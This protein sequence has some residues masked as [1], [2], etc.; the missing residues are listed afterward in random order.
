MRRSFLAFFIIER[1]DSWDLVLTERDDIFFPSSSQDAE[2]FMNSAQK[3]RVKTIS[4]WLSESDA[5]QALWHIH[6]GDP[7]KAHQPG[8]PGTLV[9]DRTI[10]VAFDSDEIDLDGD[11][12]KLREKLKGFY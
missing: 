4:S 1:V 5:G 12:E 6:F 3:D 9:P 11:I 7:T 10:S 2:P 8:A